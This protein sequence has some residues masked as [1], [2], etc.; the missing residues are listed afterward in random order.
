VNTI[1]LVDDEYS[2]VE[3]L[4]HLLE[5]EGYTV[6]TAANGQDG[7]DR[8]SEKA[9]DLVITDLM[10]PIMDG[11]E[12]LRELR[13]SAALRHVPVILITSAPASAFRDLPWA[14]LLAKPFEF[15]ELLR[16]IRRALRPGKPKGG[17]E[18]R[19]GA[20][21]QRRRFKVKLGSVVGFTT[22]ISTNG[23]STEMMRVLPAGRTVE[24]KI[25]ALGRAVDFKGCVIWSSP[26]DPNL[27]LRGRMGV[28][29]TN[30]SAELLELVNSR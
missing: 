29:F 17:H 15:E 21:R 13:K 4:T 22:D 6:L 7:L 9:P 19:N 14:D 3:V 12:L 16:A 8:A 5:E 2:I 18:R 23:F 1:L 30:A 10:M 27:N 25:E 24:G 20:A 11:D 26:G 28:S